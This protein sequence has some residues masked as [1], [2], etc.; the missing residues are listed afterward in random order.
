MAIKAQNTMPITTPEMLGA[1]QVVMSSTPTMLARFQ[2]LKDETHVPKVD[3]DCRTCT[4]TEAAR[5]MGIS[6]P[7]LYRLIKRKAIKTVE[8]NGVS[9][10]LLPS[11]FDYVRNGE[12][13]RGIVSSEG[14]A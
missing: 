14:E 8:L 9:R 11:L 10:V 2:W 6:R 4:L 7:T 13:A 12:K 1:F 3:P 5:R